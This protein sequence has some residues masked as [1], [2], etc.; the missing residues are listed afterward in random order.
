MNGTVVNRYRVTWWVDDLCPGMMCE[1]VAV[2]NRH[3]GCLPWNRL[4]R[5]VLISSN[6]FQV[7][8]V[9]AIG[10]VRIKRRLRRSEVLTFFV[11]L[12]P[13][14]E[15]RA[16]SEGCQYVGLDQEAGLAEAVDIE[17]AAT[18][19]LPA[20]VEAADRVAI[21]STNRQDRDAAAAVVRHVQNVERVDGDVIGAIAGEV[22]DLDRGGAIV[23]D[24][25]EVEGQAG[26]S[27][28]QG[29]DARAAPEAGKGGIAGNERIVALAA[30]HDIGPATSGDD[31]VAPPATKL[32]AA[33][34]PARLSALPVPV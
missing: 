19:E 2:A 15:W 28:F 9:D 1:N 24:R 12:S 5:S 27:H 31:V 34:V 33:V 21:V 22:D 4:R 32:S 18:E 8:G 13:V 6:T 29:V 16:G 10:S 26:R 17:G 25:R 7:Y 20:D 11:T 14:A 23:R 3:T 30:A